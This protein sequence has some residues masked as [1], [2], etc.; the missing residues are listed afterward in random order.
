LIWNAF[1]AIPNDGGVD[2]TINVPLEN[3]AGAVVVFPKTPNQI[4][5]F[6]NPMLKDMYLKI[7]NR[8]IPDPT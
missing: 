2:S 7:D 1:P 6:E 5:V 3:C 8:Q 4:T